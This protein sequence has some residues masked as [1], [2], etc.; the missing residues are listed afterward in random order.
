MEVYG[1]H[2][3]GSFSGL[4]GKRLWDLEKKYIKKCP[5]WGGL[6]RKKVSF[7]FH[8]G[9]ENRGGGAILFAWHT[10]MVSP[11]ASRRREEVWVREGGTLMIW[12]P[13]GRIPPRTQKPG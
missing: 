7:E 9:F 12:G 4:E 11:A 3:T 8:K 13:F 6:L 2:N 5:Q 1:V 10:P